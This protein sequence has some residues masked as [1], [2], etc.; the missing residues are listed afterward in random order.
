VTDRFYRDSAWVTFAL[1]LVNASNYVLNLGVSRLASKAEFSEVAA[2]LSLLLLV[3]VPGSAVQ[4]LLTREVARGETEMGAAEA[5][6]EASGTILPVALGAA[7]LWLVAGPLVRSF[8]HL[9]SGLTPLLIVP[10]VGLMLIL[11]LYR[12]LLQG[13]RRF[14]ALTFNIGLEAAVRVAAAIVLILLGLGAP[15]V[16]L[17]FSL[18]AVLALMIGRLVTGAPLRVRLNGWSAAARRHLVQALP[19]LVT[20]GMIYGLFSLDMLLAR[21]F[22]TQA[23][24]AEYASAA[25]TARILYYLTSSIA[26]VVVASAGAM[27]PGRAHAAPLIKGLG[28]AVSVAGAG[29]AICLLAGGGVMR[30]FFGSAFLAAAPVLP[31]L[32]AGMVA[33]SAV[34]LMAFFLLAL[35]RSSFVSVLVA[36]VALEVILVG[37]HHATM[38]EI[39]NAFTI[40]AFAAAVGLAAFTVWTLRRQ[41]PTPA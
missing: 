21:H 6:H 12:G 30:L 13:S 25:L 39:A 34:N 1:L 18:A 4:T 3:N 27:A 5:F 28:L 11:P 2:L 22:L 20:L 40:S 17:G 24:S 16:L 32:G 23:H 33:L 26:G 7:V 9:S 29:E 31:R 8:L 38:I 19:F 14:A 36:A 41:V 35:R 10:V 15:G 37:W